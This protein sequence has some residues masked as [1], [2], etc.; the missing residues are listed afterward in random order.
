[1]KK[2]T[3][4]KKRPFF[5]P[6]TIVT[7]IYQ[8]YERDLDL[9]LHVDGEVEDFTKYFIVSSKQALLK[10]YLTSETDKA[11][12]D[13]LTY[14][15]FLDVNEHMASY[16]R[17]D[18]FPT[19]DYIVSNDTHEIKSLLRARVLVRNLLGPFNWDEWFHESRNSSGSSIG[20]SFKDTSLEAK[21]TF[22]IS[23]STEVKPIFDYYLCFDSQLKQAIQN[24]N[25]KYPLDNWYEIVDH[26]RATTVAKTNEINRMIAIEP[27]GNMY[28][29]QG[30]MSM[31]YKRFLSVGLDVAS[32]PY[33]HQMLAYE[34]SITGLNATI[35]FSSASDCVSTELLR[36]LL[37]P[38]WFRVLDLVRC[39]RMSI[40]DSVIDLNMFSTMGNAGTFPLEL[41]CFWALAIAS[42]PKNYLGNSL[43]LK[44]RE[45]ITDVSVF[46]DDCILPCT[47]VDNFVAITKYVGFI[48]NDSKSYTK[49][50]DRFRESCGGDFHTG[51]NVRP[52]YL[53]RPT[54][55]RKSSLEPWLY[56]ITNSFLKKYITLYGSLSYI[57]DKE[58]LS[59]LFRLF[60][61]F[62]IHIKVVPNY[63]PDDAGLKI[64][65]DLV[66]IHACYSPRLSRIS[67]SHHGTYKFSY[68]TF[69]YRIK[70]RAFD[71]IRYATWLKNPVQ[72]DRSSATFERVNRRIGGY[73]VARGISSCWSL[74]SLHRL[75]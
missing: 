27:T 5:N 18:L 11:S 3:P 13:E 37:P 49:T 19:R 73:V 35:D 16:N 66:R 25:G 45:A 52:I 58:V 6:D 26:S 51:R 34:S 14:K 70:N 57:Y 36:W 72:S 12:L 48:V 46:G 21:F 4:V 47:W 9:L 43:F 62:G 28:F 29:Q 17:R 75:R 31:L 8:A 55:C 59:Y 1:M 56:I 39:K 22:P 7:K 20:V 68:L 33:R 30:L 67:R 69:K 53:R 23:M 42:Q 64:S 38:K 15:K 50:T 63:F 40:K 54:S 71:H 32:L 60:G 65:D 44:K 41:L 2:S 10:K 61:D 24:L 74:P